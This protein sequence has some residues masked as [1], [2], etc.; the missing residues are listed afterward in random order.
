MKIACNKDEDGEESEREG[1]GE[2]EG[3]IG[4]VGRE[5]DAEHETE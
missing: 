4:S 5:S 1:D 2:E 3:E